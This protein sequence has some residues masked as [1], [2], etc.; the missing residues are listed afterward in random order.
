MIAKLG[1]G[2]DGNNMSAGVAL[3]DESE[4]SIALLTLKPEVFVISIDTF[5]ANIPC[6]IV[7]FHVV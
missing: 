6:Y 4:E 5:N 2:D 1:K 7:E 3:S